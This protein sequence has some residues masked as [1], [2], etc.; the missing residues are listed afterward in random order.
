MHKS[1]ISSSKVSRRKLES[2]KELIRRIYQRLRQQNH[3]WGKR[4]PL[5]YGSHFAF[6]ISCNPNHHLALGVPTRGLLP[7]CSKRGRCTSSFCGSFVVH[8][9]RQCLTT[10]DPLFH[11]ML[12][13]SG[14]VRTRPSGWR[15]PI[16][17]IDAPGVKTLVQKGLRITI[18]NP[19][20]TF[21]SRPT[22]IQLQQSDGC[23]TGDRF[24]WRSPKR[25][26]RG[27]RCRQ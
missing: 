15:K 16:V 18:V 5:I 23:L 4:R 12:Q 2:G 26:S 22:I 27:M 11:A 3:L 9:L 21:Y 25:M 10:S 19:L 8:P 7:P 13:S 24:L 20:T 6:F 17:A 1:G 14:L